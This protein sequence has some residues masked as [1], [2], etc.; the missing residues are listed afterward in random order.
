MQLLFGLIQ[1]RHEAALAS[2]SSTKTAAMT[3]LN[4]LCME[5][6]QILKPAAK[7]FLNQ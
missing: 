2:H 5:L 6:I 4:K 1:Q 3:N 7:G